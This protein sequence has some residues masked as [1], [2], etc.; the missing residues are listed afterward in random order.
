MAPWIVRLLKGEKAWLRV[1]RRLGWI[2]RI[3]GEVSPVMAM[4]EVGLEGC[5]GVARYWSRKYLDKLDL[6]LPVVGLRRQVEDEDW[7]PP[8]GY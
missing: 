2:R 6:S 4:E 7:L 8:N 3:V 1:V 5:F